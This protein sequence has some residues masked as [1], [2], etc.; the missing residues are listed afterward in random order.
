[1]QDLTPCTRRG[2][3]WWIAKRSA[4]VRRRW[5][6]WGVICTGASSGRRISSPAQTARWPSAI[7]TPRRGSGNGEPSP[8]RNSCGWCCSMGCRRV[9]GAPATSVFCTPTASAWSPC[10]IW[11]CTSILAGR[12]PGSENGRPLS[13]LA[14]GRRWRSCERGFDLR[15]RR[16]TRCR[17]PP[18]PFRERIDPGNVTTLASR[19]LS[20]PISWGAG[21]PKI[22]VQ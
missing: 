21:L 9:S 11:C 7:A 12:P 3:G 2:N 19:R 18:Q 15:S 20:A 8:A 1:M 17:L 13:A 10:C 16:K 22:R 4:A 5:S 6:T 14:A